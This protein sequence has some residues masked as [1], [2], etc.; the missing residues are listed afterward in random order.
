ME[1]AFNKRLLGLLDQKEYLR[2]EIQLNLIKDSTDKKQTLFFQ[3]CVDN[4]FNM[5][6]LQALILARFSYMGRV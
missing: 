6:K 5:Q 4:A 3:S 2:L 1:T